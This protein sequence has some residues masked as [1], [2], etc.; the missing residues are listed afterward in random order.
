M[1]S[2]II[3]AIP[4]ILFASGQTMST[5]DYMFFTNSDRQPFK[6]LRKKSRINQ[7]HKVDEK[8]AKSIVK[9]LTQEDCESIKLTRSGKYLIYKISTKHYKL[10]INA[11]DGTIV[12][13]KVL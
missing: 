2:L 11:L 6:Q 9:K 8:E 4:F 7:L 13:K 5:S 12:E 10:T 1:K 3:L